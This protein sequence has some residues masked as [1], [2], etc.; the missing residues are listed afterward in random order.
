[1]I[2]N[3]KASWSGLTQ[4]EQFKFGRMRGCGPGRVFFLVPQFIFRA[5]CWQHDFYY[6]RGGDIF[7]KMEAD[8]MFFSFMLKDINEGQTKF[9]H[10]LFYTTM[11][12]LYYLWVSTF[13]LVF[14][15]YGRYRDKEEILGK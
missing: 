4:K 9:W 6:A 14:F 10:K 3:E 5:S 8:A 12:V 1:M 13:G 11:A 15:K 7:D 2:M